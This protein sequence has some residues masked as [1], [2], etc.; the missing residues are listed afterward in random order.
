VHYSFVDVELSI[1]RDFPG[2]A[3]FVDDLSNFR[4]SLVRESR[5]VKIRVSSEPY[6]EKTEIF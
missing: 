5:Y 4:V 3:Q 6:S 1:A 2:R